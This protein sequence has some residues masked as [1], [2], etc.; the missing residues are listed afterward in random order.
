MGKV[1]ADEA[2]SELRSFSCLVAGIL[3]REAIK[4]TFLIHTSGLLYCYSVLFDLT[5]N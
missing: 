1:G 2:L 3:A 4:K 5:T